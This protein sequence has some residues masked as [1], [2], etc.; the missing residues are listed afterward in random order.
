M[1]KLTIPDG[2]AK[3]IA[4]RLGCKTDATVDFLTIAL[5]NALLFDQKN[6][7]YG[8]KNISGFGSFG[9]I[10]R[11]NDKFERLKNLFNNRRSVATNES[12]ED[13]FRD[14]SNYCIIA[15]MLEH[16]CWPDYTKPT[17]PPPKRVRK[18]KPPKPIPPP[19]P[20]APMEV[21]NPF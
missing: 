14:I 1:N 13:S 19:L 2:L 20:V 8:N 5:Q 17:P 11:A 16:G 12:I 3:D 10:V 15:T 4:A 6:L 9:V 21:N 18:P 7:D